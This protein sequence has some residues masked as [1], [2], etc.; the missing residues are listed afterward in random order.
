MR[1]S[2]GAPGGPAPRRRTHPLGLLQ[3]IRQ[4]LQGCGVSL[5]HVLDLGFVVPRLLVDGLLQLGDLLLSFGSASRNEK[6][7]CLYSVNADGLECSD[8]SRVPV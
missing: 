1:L 7:T 2:D 5:P 8:H 4:L 3:L 6:V